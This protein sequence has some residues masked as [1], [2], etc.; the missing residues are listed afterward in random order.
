[1]KGTV[2]YI[3]FE[4]EPVLTFDPPGSHAILS[5]NS[6]NE[7][8]RDPPLARGQCVEDENWAVI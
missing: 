7:I 4:P 3:T 5:C 1:M 8:L 6:A 2:C